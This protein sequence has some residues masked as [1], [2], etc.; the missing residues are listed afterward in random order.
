MANWRRSLLDLQHLPT[1][2]VSAGQN[3]GAQ[4][5]LAVIAARASDGTQMAETQPAGTGIG[6]YRAPFT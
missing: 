4:V 2:F 1:S 6:E 5:G 3:W